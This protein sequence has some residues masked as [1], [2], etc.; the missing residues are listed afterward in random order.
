MQRSVHVYEV[1][2]PRHDKR[3]VDLIS[4]TLPFGRLWYGL[5]AISNAIGNEQIP[6]S[7]ITCAIGGSKGKNLRI[8]EVQLVGDSSCLALRGVL[9]HE[10]TPLS[11]A[12]KK[13]RHA[14]M[15]SSP[16]LDRIDA[17]QRRTLLHYRDIRC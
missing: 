2:P 12:L 16:I 11:L 4:E 10:R 3:G 9:T 6:R 14:V 17:D 7:Q 15:N 8:S 1:R 13:P 5:D